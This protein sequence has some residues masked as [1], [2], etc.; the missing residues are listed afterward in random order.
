MKIAC[1]GTVHAALHL[2]L[3][4]LNSLRSIFHKCPMHE[5][6]RDGI[7]SKPYFGRRFC[8]DF[9]TVEIAQQHQMC[10]FQV[11]CLVRYRTDLSRYCHFRDSLLTLSGVVDIST[12]LSTEVCHS[13]VCGYQMYKQVWLLLLEEPFCSMTGRQKIVR[14]NVYSIL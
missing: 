4:K 10:I 2:L 14:I 6:F 3:C 11:I 12:I 9:T 8:V 13:H 7:F 1:L 5:D